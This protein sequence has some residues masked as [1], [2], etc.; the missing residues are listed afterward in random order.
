MVNAKYWY[1]YLC[2]IFSDKSLATSAALSFLP[3]HQ[4]MNDGVDSVMFDG[5]KGAVSEVI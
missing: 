5:A 4:F 2:A 3:L 1:N